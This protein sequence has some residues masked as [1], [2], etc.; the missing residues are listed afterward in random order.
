MPKVSILLTSYNHEEYIGKS[1]ESILNQDFTDYELY[2][3]DDCSTDNSWNIITKYKD[4]RIKAIRHSKNVGGALNPEF[5]NQLNGEYMAIAHCDDEWEKTKLRKQVEFLDKHKKYGACF[6]KVMLIDEQEEIISPSAPNYFNVFDQKNRS[7]YEWL[8]YFFYRGNALCHPSVLIR[9][10]SQKKYNLYAHGLASFPDYYRWVKLCLNE[11]IFIIQEELTYFRIRSKG[12]N[13]SGDNIQNQTRIPLERMMVLK[14]YFNIKR[15][16]EL[17][18]IFPTSKE[19][20]INNK[21]NIK[22]AI[23]MTMIKE[24]Q[25]NVDKL[26]GLEKLYEMLLN[27]KEEKEIKEIY[28]FTSRDFTKLNY[29]S[30]VFEVKKNRTKNMKLYYS[31]N[32][33]FS[34]EN[35]ILKSTYINSNNDFFVTFELDKKINGKFRFDP[36]ESILQ[37]YSSIEIQINGEKV[38]YTSNGIVKDKCIEFYT[39]D[40]QIYFEKKDSKIIEISGHVEKFNYNELLLIAN[41]NKIGIFRKIKRSIKNFK[42]HM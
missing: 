21:I 17:L 29:E 39:C 28:N 9:I 15:K 3:V 5:V 6:T 42:K 41:K 10:S 19:F 22:F 30:D 20:I 8:N 27:E 32:G 11:E 4:K 23:A 13:T 35:S 25:Y 14:E 16:Q 40:P 34:E 18:K 26:C 31:E 12:K 2:I 7:R 38:E 36:H 24:S 37:N 33:N 1:I